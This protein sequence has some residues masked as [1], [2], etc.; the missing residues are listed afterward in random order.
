MIELVSSSWP[1]FSSSLSTSRKLC[2]DAGADKKG[3]DEWDD[4]DDDGDYDYDE[5]DDEDDNI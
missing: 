1:S 4:D 3:E 5:N 2:H